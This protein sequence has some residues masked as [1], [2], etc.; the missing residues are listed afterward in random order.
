M[1]CKLR[2]L[3]RASSSHPNS[4]LSRLSAKAYTTEG[5]SKKKNPGCENALVVCIELKS[6]AH[7]Y[8]KSNEASAPGFRSIGTL[9]SVSDRQWSICHNSKSIHRYDTGTQQTSPGRQRLL[10]SHRETCGYAMLV[11]T[12]DQTTIIIQDEGAFR[13]KIVRNV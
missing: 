2:Q 13:Y 4:T 7:S 1:P 3:W 5:V 9:D 12:V 11:S 8:R 6:H 10:H